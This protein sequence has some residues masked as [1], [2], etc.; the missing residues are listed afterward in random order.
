M[1]TELLREFL[2]LAEEKNYWKAAERLYMNQ[3]TLSKHIRSLEKAL[4]VPLFERTTRMVELTDYGRTF[5]PYAQTLVRT[6]ADC[7]TALQHQK[8]LHSNSVRIDCIPTM[9]QY[10]LAGLML[11]FR[12][13]NPDHPLRVRE[14][15]SCHA[16][17]ALA[18]HSCEVAICWELPPSMIPDDPPIVAIPFVRDRLVLVLEK[19]HPLSGRKTVSVSGLKEEHLCFLKGYPYDLACGV[20]RQAGFSPRVACYTDCLE[21]ILDVISGGTHSALLMERYTQ[22]ALRSSPQLMER[23][24]TADL[25]PAVPATLCLCYLRDVPLSPAAQRFLAFF[26]QWR[27]PL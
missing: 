19:S 27:K 21:N 16:R 26:E 25:S 18:Q 12:E 3:S 9:A 23:F 6:Q 8:D 4:S 11:S 22:Y 13:Q 1:E 5:L 15:D 7:A 2:I 20:C 17:Q 10:G 14:V 24:T